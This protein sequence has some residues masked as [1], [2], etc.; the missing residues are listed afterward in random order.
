MKLKAEYISRRRENEKKAIEK[1]QGQ[2]GQ[3]HAFVT[4]V[5]FH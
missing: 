5:D 2:V 1:K 3:L 4:C